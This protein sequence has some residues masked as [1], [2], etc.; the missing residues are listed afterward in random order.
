M[1]FD[2]SRG[3]TWYEACIGEA[4]KYL[5][6][7]STSLALIDSTTARISVLGTRGRMPWSTMLRLVYDA[8]VARSCYPRIVK[9]EQGIV[10][11]IKK[12]SD[13]NRIG[14][15]LILAVTTLVSV[16]VS[17]IAFEPG[18]AG[19]IP[20]TP[21]GYLVGLLVPLLIHEL[22]H[23]T[24]L[25][26]YKTPASLPYLLP[27]PPLQAGFLG[28]FGAVINLRWLP[29][30]D[31][32]LAVSAIAG[33]LAGFLAA[34]PF[35]VWGIHASY[36][37]PAAA[38]RGAI[39]LVPLIFMLIPPPRPVGAHEVLVLS[40]M[41]FAAFIVFFVTFLNLIPVA[42]LDGGHI[43]RALLGYRGHKIVSNLALLTLIA[44][45]VR[46]PMLGIFALIAAFF[47]FRL[48][49]GHP[50]SAMGIRSPGDPV[51]MLVAVLYAILL[52]LTIPV[53]AG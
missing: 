9:S 51:L 19:G 12:S 44:S 22:G 42:M 29:P 10:L 49:E 7:D 48:K 33:P 6:L 50:G 45:A 30:S 20:N 11:L 16:Y 38:V 25:R 39:P 17:G 15:A 40:P 43:V 46:W 24:A 2:T 35:A 3:G 21:L 4:S 28:T 23:W 8:L 52:I 18:P 5:E 53:P 1:G 13:K 27:A 41:G 31:R 26:H 36:V 37:M 32:G 34:L 47:H 14:L